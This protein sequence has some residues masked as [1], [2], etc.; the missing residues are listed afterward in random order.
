MKFFKIGLL[1]ALLFIEISVN[2]EDMS[3]SAEIDKIYQEDQKTRS[4][5][6]RGDVYDRPAELKSDATHRMR[7]FEMMVDDLPWSAEDFA[8]VSRIFQHTNTGSESEE[9]ESW[10]SQENHLLGFFF[11]R[12]AVRLGL[13]NEGGGM[14]G[15]VDRYLKASGIPRDYGLEL[16]SRTPLK[17]CPINPTITDEQRLNAGL[18]L[19]LNEIMLEFC[20]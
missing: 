1:L 18:P 12:K 16:V 4:L 15:R 14:V 5:F 7:L 20:H 17:V 10:R 13:L 2:A 9:N 19:K 6:K 3:R 8:L 11:A